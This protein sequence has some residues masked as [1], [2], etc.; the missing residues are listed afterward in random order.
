MLRIVVARGERPHGREARQRKRCDDRLA[1]AGEHDVGV[2]AL[3][4]LES[5]ADGV[6]AGGAGGGRRG[7]RPLAAVADRD[8]A[9][10]EV[11]LE[12]TSVLA[13][14]GQLHSTILNALT[15]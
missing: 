13:T 5:V 10:G 14:T 6:R 9:G 1:A 12:T 11:T 15:R 7:V 8:L 2:V 4:D 3:D